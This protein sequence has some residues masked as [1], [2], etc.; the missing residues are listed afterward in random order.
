ME[1]QENKLNSS[2]LSVGQP[3]TTDRND[4]KRKQALLDGYKE[5]VFDNSQTDYAKYMFRPENSCTFLRTQKKYEEQHW[6]YC[7]TCGLT[8]NTGACSVCVRVCHKGHHVIYFR[9][10]TFFCDCQDSGGNCSFAS[11]IAAL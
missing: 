1:R 4:R 6:Y 3:N 5:E 8:G 10:S 2:I 11:Q 7:Y 9:K